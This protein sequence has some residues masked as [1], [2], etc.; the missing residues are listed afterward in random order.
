MS[1]T[2]APRAVLES[3]DLELVAQRILKLAELATLEHLQALLNSQ[4]GAMLLAQDG[5]AN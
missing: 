2:P 4:A 3:L 5:E 1:P